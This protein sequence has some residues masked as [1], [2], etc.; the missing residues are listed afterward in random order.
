MLTEFT[1]KQYLQIDVAGAFG[2]DKKDWEERLAWVQEH[3]D[4]LESLEKQAKEPAM[5]YAATKALR[6][7]ERGEPSGF[8]ISL[9]AT[10][11]GMQILACLT[12]CAKTARHVNLVDTGHR[13]NAYK[14][15]YEAMLT[16]TGGEA[17]INLDDT[18]SAIMKAFYT[19]KAEP[20]RVFGE[21]ELL[22]SFY[23]T[24]SE[25][26]PGA[27]EL[28]EAMMA[29][30]NP[31]ALSHDWVLPDNFHVHVKV[32]DTQRE[33]VNFLEKPYEVAFKVNR[34]QPEGRSLGANLVHSID[35]MIVRD[36]QRRCGYDP[37]TVQRVVEAIEST[38]QREDRPKDQTVIKL[39]AHAQR[40]GY[41][42][43]RIIDFLDRENMG[44]VDGMQILE[45]LL[46]FPKKP[47]EVISNHD[48]FRCLPNYGNDLR[49]QYNRIL[50]DLSKS[51][52]LADLLTQIT[53][54]PI[55]VNKY[56]DLSEEILNANY[57]LS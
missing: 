22:S 49:R 20:R 29:F 21:G 6:A 16:R 3:H 19:S 27:W 30:W 31:R 39:W 13:E 7:A 56:S 45:L 51:T 28:T 25:E 52:L 48:C 24:L 35:G 41:L 17:R 12:G 54:R 37:R 46:T 2:L 55:Q 11:S 9:D 32:M 33:S 14:A 36:M 10:A 40:S 50:A 34:P 43:P 4:D 23:E 1:G 8:P 15:L 57:S 26:T 44:H 42:S 38:T 53:G 18:K 5:F 47:F